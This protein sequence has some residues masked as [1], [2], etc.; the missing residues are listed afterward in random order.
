VESSCLDEIWKLPVHFK[1]KIDVLKTPIY[2][3][4][5][6]GA[7]GAPLEGFEKNVFEG[8]SPHVVFITLGSVGAKRTKRKRK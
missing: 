7:N 6:R 4:C 8:K 5:D 2:S 3:V 1:K